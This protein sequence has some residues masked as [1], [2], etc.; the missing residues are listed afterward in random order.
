MTS[1]DRVEVLR[2][3]QKM[4][5]CTMA[6]VERAVATDTD[7]FSFETAQYI[8]AYSDVIKQLTEEPAE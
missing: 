5:E 3:V 8:D 7:I 2:M 6:L 4:H 1:K